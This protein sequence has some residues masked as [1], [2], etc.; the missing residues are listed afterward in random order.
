MPVGHLRVE[1]VVGAGGGLVEA[2]GG[3][4]GHCQYSSRHLPHTVLGV[5]EFP[6]HLPHQDDGLLL[7]GPVQHTEG[8]VQYTEEVVGGLSVYPIFCPG[9]QVQF[10]ERLQTWRGLRLGPPWRRN[11]TR[12]WR[13]LVVK[14]PKNLILRPKL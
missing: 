4:G 10:M 9:S 13:M 12:L 14:M 1:Q 11:W 3:C 8:P 5:L 7:Q 6:P 2:V